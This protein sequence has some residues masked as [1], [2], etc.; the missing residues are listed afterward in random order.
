MKPW[1]FMLFLIVPLAVAFDYQVGEVKEVYFYCV[2]ASDGKPLGTA[3]S[4]KVRNDTGVYYEV[5]ALH[6][7]EIGVFK[8][9]ISNLTRGHCYSFM[10]NCTSAGTFNLEWGTV[11]TETNMTSSG[12]SNFASVGGLVF[13]SGL[14][15]YLSQFFVHIPI[16]T[17]S[18]IMLSEV[19]LAGALYFG[20]KWAEL[21]QASAAVLGTMNFVFWMFVII[22]SL[23][24]VGFF[25]YAVVT[26]V[27]PLFTPKA[28]GLK[29]R[30]L[31]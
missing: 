12:V 27:V 17:L 6:N 20:L 24:A 2:N 21:V 25:W 23:S 14:F 28:A 30:T 13:S 16:L 11:C 31:K 1:L 5:A 26:T 3:A 19:F 8:H 7:E 9:N 15:L 18:M 10:L 29:R 4:L 22:L